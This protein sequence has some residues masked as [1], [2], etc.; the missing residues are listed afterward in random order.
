MP[1]SVVPFITGLS[2]LSQFV[3]PLI[4]TLGVASE[5]KQTLTHARLIQWTLYW[6]I[7][8]TWT[9]GENS[10]F[11]WL[12]EYLPLYHELKWILF[13]WLASPKFQGAA[14][15]WFCVLQNPASHH[16]QQ[17]KN[18]CELHLHRVIIS[19]LPLTP[20]T[21]SWEHAQNSKSK[22]EASRALD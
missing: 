17:I 14:W 19:I 22:I 9:L 18:F 2:V 10:L 12:A 4:V 8:A 1:V 5:P 3:Y 15:L 21:T 7:Y 20:T 16:F 11:W 13:F 6:M